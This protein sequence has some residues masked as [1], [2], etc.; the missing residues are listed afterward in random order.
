MSSTGYYCHCCFKGMIAGCVCFSSNHIYGLL[1]RLKIQMN[2]S[3]CY[4]S[5]VDLIVAGLCTKQLH[6]VLM[7]FFVELFCIFEA[8]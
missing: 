4:Y 2:L 7:Q 8:R 1:A 6:L 5:D 3:R